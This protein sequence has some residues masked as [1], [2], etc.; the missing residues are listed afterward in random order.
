MTIG[1]LQKL[2]IW[3][4]CLSSRFWE[5]LARGL[6]LVTDFYWDEEKKKFWTKKIQ[7]GWFSKWPFF[8]TANSQIFFVKISW[9]GPWVS[10]IDWCKGHWWGSTYMAVRLSDIRPKT[11]KICIFCVFRLF[12]SSCQTV[13]RPYRLCQTNALRI[14]QFY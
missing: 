10:R 4:T 11:G 3:S 14:N 6:L 13:S 2:R 5:L 9:I 1:F 12:L 8:K 7:N